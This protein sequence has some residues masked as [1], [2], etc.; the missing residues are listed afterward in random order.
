MYKKL[1]E[2]KLYIKIVEIDEIHNFVAN[3][4]FI[5]HRFDTQIC[6]ASFRSVWTNDVLK[7]SNGP[8]TTP[9][10]INRFTQVDKV[11]VCLCKCIYT[12]AF[13]QRMWK[14]CFDRLWNCFFSSSVKWMPHCVIL[15]LYNLT[16]VGK[17][18]LSNSKQGNWIHRKTF[19]SRN[20]P[21]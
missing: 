20:P 18:G 10:S 7:F 15:L 16:T 5:W 6:V 1:E 9:A 3:K 14:I 21:D 13:A 2:D 19:Y 4:I 12:Q 8:I 11:I 17:V